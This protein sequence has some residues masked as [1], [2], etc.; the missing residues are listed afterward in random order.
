VNNSP[1]IVKGVA[2]AA[3]RAGVL[4]NMKLAAFGSADYSGP[5]SS[6]GP[7][8]INLLALRM[9]QHISIPGR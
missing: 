7:K 6:A 1:E 4:L 8:S 5:F 2:E 3:E 9:P